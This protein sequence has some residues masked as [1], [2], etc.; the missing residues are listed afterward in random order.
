MGESLGHV[1]LSLEENNSG[2]LGVVSPEHKEKSYN[3]NLCEHERPSCA[4]VV[5]AG[6]RAG[7]P[8]FC[9]NQA[10]P[11]SPYCVEHRALCRVAPGTARAARIAAAQ[12]EDAAAPP[13]P[14][15]AHLAACGLLEP[16]DP[17]E[18]AEALAALGRARVPEDEA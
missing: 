7:P 16:A 9:V 4:Y 11:G 5:T 10:V 17:A 2:T 8:Q 1:A 18:D 12:D 13:P 15:F 3:N 14:E 6:S